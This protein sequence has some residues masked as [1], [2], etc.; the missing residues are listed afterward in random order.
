MPHP[1]PSAR[2]KV[3]GWWGQARALSRPPDVHFRAA[4]PG[5]VPHRVADAFR[6][7]VSSQ[8]TGRAAGASMPAFYARVNHSAFEPA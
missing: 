4:F 8:Q 1:E 5:V 6:A 2:G 7:T 3:V